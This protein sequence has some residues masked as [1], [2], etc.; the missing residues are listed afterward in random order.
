MLI[1][2][3]AFSRHVCESENVMNVTSKPSTQIK[4]LH[5]PR[6]NNSTT[7]LSLI[8]IEPRD[9]MPGLCRSGDS[10]RAGERKRPDRRRAACVRC[11]PD[12]NSGRLHRESCSLA[13]KSME[14]CETLLRLGG[15]TID[16]STAI[17]GAAVVS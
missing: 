16:V 1:V 6:I 15:H 17:A 3:I 12:T 7:T 5:T 11:V 4:R 9:G 2:A 14:P 10:V 13:A 8:L